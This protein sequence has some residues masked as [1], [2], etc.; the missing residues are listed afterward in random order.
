MKVA[1]EIQQ[2]SQFQYM[3]F[4]PGCGCGHGLRVGQSSGPSWTFDGDLEKP[5]FSP[6]LLI[7][8]HDFTPKGRADYEAWKAAGFPR[9]DDK[10]MKFESAPTRC[11][12]YITGGEIRFLSDCTHALAG[13]TVP[14]QP[15]EGESLR[16][17]AS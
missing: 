16:G 2:P 1:L 8:V 5:T 15:F 17:V 9:E 12:S 14:L 10:P 3:I 13:K 11:H 4:C 6:S 7:E